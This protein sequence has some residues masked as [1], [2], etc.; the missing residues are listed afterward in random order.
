MFIIIIHSR[1]RD[2]F[3]PATFDIRLPRHTRDI[4]ITVRCST[5]YGWW[6]GTVHGMMVERR[7][8]NGEL[9]FDLQLTGDH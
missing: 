1:I 2:E 6:C 5:F 3:I 9:A 4:H 7:F 8:L